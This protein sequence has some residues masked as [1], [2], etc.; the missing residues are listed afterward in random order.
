MHICVIVFLLIIAAASEVRAPVSH[1]HRCPTS[2]NMSVGWI[3]SVFLFMA[4]DG[5]VFPL[6]LRN[7]GQ[8]ATKKIR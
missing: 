5:C 1:D 4:T 3:M 8:V 6:Y 7:Y 2:V